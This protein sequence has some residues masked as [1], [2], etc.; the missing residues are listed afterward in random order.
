M[1][2]FV[3]RFTAAGE[4]TNLDQ[5]RGRRSQPV[6]RGLGEA[7]GRLC[8]ERDDVSDS[9]FL[10][11]HLSPLLLLHFFTSAIQY[12]TLSKRSKNQFRMHLLRVTPQT[13]S[14]S[15]AWLCDARS[16]LFVASKLINWTC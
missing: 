8:G 10:F 14:G 1:S 4:R 11:L 13:N 12:Y 6:P 9:C 7:N 3:S 15:N 2:S 5:V 16:P